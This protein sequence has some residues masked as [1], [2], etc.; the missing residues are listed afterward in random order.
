[1][2]RV[3]RCLVSVACFVWQPGRNH[4]QRQR[5]KARAIWPNALTYT[6]VYLLGAD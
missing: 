5:R 3:W 2:V 4:G 1:M 6:R